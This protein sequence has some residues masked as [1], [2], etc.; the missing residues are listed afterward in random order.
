M[1]TQF[2]LFATTDAALE[3]KLAGTPWSVEK[4]RREFDEIAK[5]QAPP[6]RTEG[7]NSN[8]PWRPLDKN[9]E[10]IPTGNHD[11]GYCLVFRGDA[12]EVDEVFNDLKGTG[13]IATEIDGSLMTA[14]PN[15]QHW[16]PGAE[17]GWMFHDRRAAKS[18][19]GASSLVDEN[20][21]GK[22]VNVLVVDQGFSQDYIESLGGTFGG[23]I[24]MTVPAFGAT[25]LPGQVEAPYTKKR[26]VHGN[27]IARNVLDLAPDVTIFDAPIIPRRIDNVVSFAARAAWAYILIHVLTIIVD[28]R[29]VVSNAWG[30]PNRFREQNR[31]D[32]TENPTNALN[33]LVALL[34]E[35]ADVVFSAGNSGQFCPDRR[36]GPYDAGPGR[37]IWGANA[38]AGVISVGASRSDALWIGMSSQGPGPKSLTGGEPNEKPDFCVPSWFH[39]DHDP[40]LSNTGTSASCGLAAGAVAALREHW[41][42]VPPATMLTALRDGARETW[43]RGWNGR[44]GAGV[45]NISGAMT[46][47]P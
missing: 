2:I 1:A 8:N 27:M 19:I 44:M 12:G 40:H 9:G 39:E 36:T 34:T 3:Q 47:L 46:H 6:F 14:A 23:G 25:P 20:L 15:W 35:R 38:L 30:I 45:L 24:E 37:S 5:E 42:A 17:L 32:Y 33:V 41:D 26:R 13:A 31:G 29:W 21:T 4:I 7:G 43:H 11:L 16:C 22:N 28:G 18:L 10:E